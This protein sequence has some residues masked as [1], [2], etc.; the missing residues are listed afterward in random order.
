M[1]RT[2]LIALL[3]LAAA[4]T[5]CG[6]S[7]VAPTPTLAPQ[8][9]VS[10]P[11][12][13]TDKSVIL[14]AVDVLSE[15]LRTLGVGNF[16]S[17]SGTNM[18]FEIPFDGTVDPAAIE[19]VLRTAGVVS[20]IGWTAQDGDPPQAGDPAPTGGTP[21]FDAAAQI[22]SATVVKPSEAGGNPGVEITL[23]PAGT[24]ALATW[25]KAHIGDNLV[26][27]VDGTVL[28]SA[29]VMSDI[30]DGHV[31]LSFPATTPIRPEV[32]AAIL[33]SGP[34]PPGWIAP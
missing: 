9:T 2:R 8:L 30:A 31:V 18:T 27:V 25:S 17:S 3:V 10:V 34:L 14:A 15:R 32:I 20:V 1:S 22:G 24:Q 7:S 19:A 26:I 6:P 33:S 13:T 12:P 29:M 21:A 11:I 4:V 28:D 16:S 5:A 23:D